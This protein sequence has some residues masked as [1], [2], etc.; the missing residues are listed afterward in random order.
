[1]LLVATVSAAT[2]AVGGV[3]D[4]FKYIY[5]PEERVLSEG[6]QVAALV[7]EHSDPNL[8]ILAAVVNYNHSRNK[9]RV[10]DVDIGEDNN[11][12]YRLFYNCN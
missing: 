5:Y 1:M 4:E 8:W 9:Y 11:P 12:K 10:R 7:D 3:S 6:D 2:E